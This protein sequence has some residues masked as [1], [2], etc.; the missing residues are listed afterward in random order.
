MIHTET[1][2]TL[3]T[4]AE[5]ET[6]LEKEETFRYNVSRE[7]VTD[8]G[9]EGAFRYGVSRQTVTEVQTEAETNGTERFL[10]LPFPSFL[11]SVALVPV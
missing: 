5:R 8:L 10:F 1:F 11:L 7:T 4:E 3:V 9:R 6:E 2:F